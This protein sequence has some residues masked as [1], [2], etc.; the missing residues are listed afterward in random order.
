MGT[1]ETDG[2]KRRAIFL[3]RDGVINENRQDYVKTWDEFVFLPGIFEPLGLLAQSP[4]LIVVITNQSAINRGLV[5]DEVVNE[6][7]RKMV[8]QVEKAGGR[9]DGVYY[10]PHIPGETCLCRK[11][12]PGLLLRAAEELHIDLDQSYCVGDKLADIAA[13][14]AVG[15]RSILV[16]TGEG[17][18]QD[19]DAIDD[20]V[21]VR[22]LQCAVELIMKNGFDSMEKE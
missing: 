8:S 15:C 9:I 12:Q 13:G 16:L 3:D 14:K 11:P 20:C 19:L 2:E 17:S 21:V 1:K 5:T 6:I 4:Y 10:C 18:K 22:D 7:N